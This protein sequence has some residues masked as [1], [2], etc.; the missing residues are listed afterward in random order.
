MIYL[1]LVTST[2]L[3]LAGAWRDY[4]AALA[5]VNNDPVKRAIVRL[6]WQGWI[7]KWKMEHDPYPRSPVNQA[8]MDDVQARIALAGLPENPA[9][10]H[11][12]P[13]PWTN[14]RGDQPCTCL[15]C[16]GL[17]IHTYTKLDRFHIVGNGEIEAQN[18]E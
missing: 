2:E 17:K 10:A 1:P 6:I 18:G 14:P 5:P 15:Y 16:R 12:R 11:A 13:A 4:R 3:E 7:G 8:M 9:L